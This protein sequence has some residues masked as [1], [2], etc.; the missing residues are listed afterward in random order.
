MQ[1]YQPALCLIHLIAECHIYYLSLDLYLYFDSDLLNYI[2]LILLGIFDYFAYFVFGDFVLGT[3][4][5][6]DYIVQELKNLLGLHMLPQIEVI[7]LVHII[8]GWK[9][10]VYNFHLFELVQYLEDNYLDLMHLVSLLLVF[11][12]LL[13][14]SQ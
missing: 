2:E 3:F 1:L 11:L 5:L 8:F 7:L 6:F 4:A 10:L 12:F 9:F 14:L 13:S